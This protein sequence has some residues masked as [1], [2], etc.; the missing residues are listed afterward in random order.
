[1]PPLTFPKP[2]PLP[3]PP[4]LPTLSSLARQPSSALLTTPANQVIDAHDIKDSVSVT[5]V[6]RVILRLKPA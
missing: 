4:F 2:S 5:N 1:M 3:P 6:R